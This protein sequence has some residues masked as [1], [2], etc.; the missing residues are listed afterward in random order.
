M[1][2][3]GKPV[4]TPEK[5]FFTI[6][7]LII[8]FNKNT[9]MFD[10]IKDVYQLQKMAKELK[11]ELKNTHIEAEVDGVIVI[12]DGEQE[13]ISITWAEGAESNPKKLQ[14]NIVKASNKGIKKAQQ[15]AAEKMKPLMSGMN[16]P[17]LPAEEKK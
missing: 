6:K 2:K 12:V 11:K 1:P 15:I 7:R 17:N 13:V 14:E 3:D 5:G 4:L 10:K 16:M 8:T 9:P